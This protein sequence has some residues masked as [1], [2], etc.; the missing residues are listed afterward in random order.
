MV[1]G[2]SST[3]LL[4]GM[5]AVL[6]V[7]GGGYRWGHQVAADHWAAARAEAADAVARGERAAAEARS[8]G[9]RRFQAADALARRGAVDRRAALERDIARRPPQPDC[10]LDAVALQL[11]NDAVGAGNGEPLAAGSVPGD[12]PADTSIDGREP[13]K[14]P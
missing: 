12:V 7:G 8:E 9:N 10:G 14:P 1:I 5:V 3:R 11:F 2:F 4:A 13:D 6:L